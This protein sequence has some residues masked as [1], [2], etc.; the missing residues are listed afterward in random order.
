[1]FATPTFRQL[2]TTADRQQYAARYE[3]CSG[4]P[5]PSD[6][7]LSDENKVFGIYYQKTLIGG[8]MLGFGQDPRTVR[9]FASSE[10]QASV[11]EAMGNTDD[12]TELCCLWL[13]RKYQTA[14][15]I[16]TFTWVIIIYALLRYAKRRLVFGTCSRGLARLYTSSKRA[17]LLH[18]DVVN[19]KQTFIFTSQKNSYFVGILNILLHKFSRKARLGWWRLRMKRA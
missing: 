8:F 6:Y 3:A 12:Y 19:R 5:I 13:A 16:N 14:F 15:L 17:H 2:S 11:Q 9:L 4:L 7:I 10:A 18:E 1:M